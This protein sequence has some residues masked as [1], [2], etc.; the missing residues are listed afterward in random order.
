MLC[1]LMKMSWAR[2]EEVGRWASRLSESL[3]TA[4]TGLTPRVVSVL[5]ALGLPADTAAEGRPALSDLCIA[6]RTDK[7]SDQSHVRFVL[8]EDMGQTLI[9]T[10]AWTQIEETLAV[11]PARRTS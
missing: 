4:A 10:L 7:K 11:S 8:M 5:T 9:R 2:L 1:C 6:A 3:G